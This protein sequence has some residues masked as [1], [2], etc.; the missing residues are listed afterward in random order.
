MDIDWF[1]FGAQVLNFLILVG[2]LRYVLYGP[3]TAALDRREERIRRRQEEAEREREEAEREAEA[4]REE[5]RALEEA[6]DERLREAQ[7]EAERLREELEEEVRQE[8]AESRERWQRAVR[9]QQESLLRE[10]RERV[11]DH[12]VD[13]TRG[14]LRQLADRELESHAVRVFARRLEGL[15]PSEAEDFRRAAGE[16]DDTVQVRTRFELDGDEREALRAAVHDR[17]GRDLELE[18]DTS[19]DLVLGVELRAGD[20][21]VAWSAGDRLDLAE[22]EVSELLE[23][24]VTREEMA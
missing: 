13:V 12:A 24:E 21:K 16:E 17:I 5:R 20:R 18:F 4:Y 9:R 1:T 19:W 11:A 6:R 8:A 15:E 2:L 23:S 22:R 10:V 14:L 7:H 3:V